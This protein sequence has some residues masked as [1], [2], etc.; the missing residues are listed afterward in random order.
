ED[1]ADVIASLADGYYSGSRGFSAFAKVASTHGSLNRRNSTAFIM[2][3]AGPLPPVMHS[4][5]IP[6]RMRELTGSPWPAAR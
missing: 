5:D 4:R 1:P 6:A 2:S 3:T